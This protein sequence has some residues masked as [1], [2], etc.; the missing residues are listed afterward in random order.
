MTGVSPQLGVSRSCRVVQRC[1][2]TG[3][4]E[5]SMPAFVRGGL[6][7][8]LVGRARSVSPGASVG[9]SAGVLAVPCSARAKQL[10]SRRPASPTAVKPSCAGRRTDRRRVSRSVCRVPPVEVF[11][12]SP[13][14]RSL[15]RAPRGG[16]CFV[17]PVEVFV[18]LRRGLSLASEEDFPLPPRRALS[19]PP[20]RALSL[21]PEEVFVLASE[22][23]FVSAPPKA[24]AWFGPCLVRG[25]CNALSG[26]AA[27]WVPPGASPF[28]PP[29]PAS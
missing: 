19:L 29:K 4:D 5:P 28:L 9:A 25:L 17:P 15:F 12:S 18:R 2:A 13:Q 22:E 11:V 27:R 3:G 6:G 14:W 23:G 20:R 16:L 24:R 7:Q 21:P 1:A 10:F 8:C 26:R